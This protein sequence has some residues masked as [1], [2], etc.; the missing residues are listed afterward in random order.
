MHVDILSLLRIGATEDAV[1]TLE[2]M[3]DNATLALTHKTNNPEELPPEVVRALKQ[4]KTYREIHPPE[5]ERVAE[6]LAKVPQVTDYKKECQAGICRLLEYK[7][8]EAQQSAEADKA[9][10]P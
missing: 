3:V 8:Q 1:N 2:G 7:K 9:A 4:I 10:Q 6:A 5:N